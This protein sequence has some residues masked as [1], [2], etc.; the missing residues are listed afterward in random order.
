MNPSRSEFSPE[1][2]ASPYQQREYYGAT[3]SRHAPSPHPQD[4]FGRNYRTP[5]PAVHRA[6]SSMDMNSAPYPPYLPT[7]LRSPPYPS[8]YTPVPPPD[9]YRDEF[10]GDFSRAPVGNGYA[11]LHGDSGDEK[12][13]II[14]LMGV[15]GLPTVAR[16]W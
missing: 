8:H 15:T 1:A 6:S 14:A 2:M 11:P 3:E 5:S 7:D 4:D 10:S 16:T 13:I 12:D 9:T